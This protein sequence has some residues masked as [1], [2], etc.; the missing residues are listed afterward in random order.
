MLVSGSGLVSAMRASTQFQ[1]AQ[2]QL[3]E[4]RQ[5]NVDAA[6]TSERPLRI[7]T[8]AGFII[9]HETDNLWSHRGGAG[10]GIGH[11]GRRWP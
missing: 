8:N 9:H 5:Q 4:K 2:Q 6:L 1:S 10:Q 3:R 7:R 11:S